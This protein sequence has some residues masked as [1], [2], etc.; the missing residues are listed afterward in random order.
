M[1][2]YQDIHLGASN[3]VASP[4]E[5]IEYIIDYV[6]KSKKIHFFELER[7][8]KKVIETE[9]SLSHPVIFLLTV[10]RRC[11]FCGSLLLFVFVFA[12]WYV[13]FLQPCGHLLGKC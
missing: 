11:F 7:F 12:C 2:F 10:P 3:L 5:D 1:K 13:C 6:V 8:A 9:T 4:M